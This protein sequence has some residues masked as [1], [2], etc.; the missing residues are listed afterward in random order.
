MPSLS[1]VLHEIFKIIH[2]AN[3]SDVRIF[4]L[5]TTGGLGVDPGTLV[6]TKRGYSGALEPFFTQIACGKKKE[7]NSETDEELTHDLYSFIKDQGFKVEIGNTIATNDF[8]E[9]Q[10]RLDGSLC[11]YTKEEK[12][13][14]LLK[15]HNECGILNFEMESTLLNALCKRAKIK[16]AI[17]CVALVNRFETDYVTSDGKQIQEWEDNLLKIAVAYIKSKSNGFSSSLH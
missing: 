1:V 17:I 7:Y 13:E 5:G 8:Y 6:L 12:L 15:A 11:S 14:F 2:Y 9:E 10:A 4:R 3:C 16:C